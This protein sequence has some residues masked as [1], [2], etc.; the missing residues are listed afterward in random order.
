M[1]NLKLS[2]LFLTL[3]KTIQPFNSESTFL[4][5][6]I[7]PVLNEFDKPKIL[8]NFFLNMMTNS[9]MKMPIEHKMELRSLRS[10]IGEMQVVN[11][12]HK[13]F[14]DELTNQLIHSIHNLE[15][16]VDNMEQNMDSN[17][18]SLKMSMNHVS[19]NMPKKELDEQYE[20]IRGLLNDKVEEDLEDSEDKEGRKL[21]RIG[22]LERNMKDLKKELEIKKKIKRLKRQLKNV[23]RKGKGKKNGKI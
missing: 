13:G 4:A 7:V 19:G 16:S 9:N 17:V 12:E 3:L 21:G 6:N 1:K 20:N 14:L 15:E 18:Q 8:N 5:D 2:I 23:D 10:K 11:K 22:R